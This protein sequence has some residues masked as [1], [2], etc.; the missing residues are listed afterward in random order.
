MI[1]KL[2]LLSQTTTKT[3]LQDLTSTLSSPIW[4]ELI[5]LQ[6]HMKK[7]YMHGMLR[8]LQQWNLSMLSYL[9]PYF[10]FC[11]IDQWLRTNISYSICKE[12]HLLFNIITI[13]K[14]VS[15]VPIFSFIYMLFCFTFQTKYI[16]VFLIF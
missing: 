11:C 10:Y 6:L 8:K 16:N 12:S 1:L 3:R 14:E 13:Y 7:Q 15:Y 9:Q 4:R 2:L 5:G